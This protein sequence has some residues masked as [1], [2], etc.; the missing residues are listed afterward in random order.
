VGTIFAKAGITEINWD[1][2]MRFVPMGVTGAWGILLLSLI[3][4]YVFGRELRE[5]TDISTATLPIRREYF[6]VAKMVVI[7]VWIV[8]L[9]ALAVLVDIVVVGTY[10]GFETFA[11]SYLWRAFVDTLYACVPIYLTL[12]VVAWLSLT[13]RGYLR[14]MVFAVVAFMLSTSMVGSKYAAYFPWSMPIAAFG[15][16]WRPLGGELPAA[17]WAIALAVFAVGLAGT[18]HAMNRAESRA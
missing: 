6:V 14:P 7:A 13:R 15:V 16:T 12:P 10:M 11:W 18:L 2:S 3:A 5:G 9:A 1:S 4:A 8:G 17:S